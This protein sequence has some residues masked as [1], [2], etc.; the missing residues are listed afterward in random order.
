MNDADALSG[1]VRR[2]PLY[3]FYQKASYWGPVF[4]LYF[5]S[6]LTLP[7]VLLLEAVYYVAVVLLEVPTGQLADRIGGRRVLLAASLAQAGAC[8][9]FIASGSFAVLA[10]GQVL[11]ALGMSLG[12]GS[13]TAY[14]FALLQAARRE[15]E[16]GDREAVAARSILYSQALS[17]LVGGA[18]AVVDLRA[19]YALTLGS[20]LL[21]AWIAFRFVHV[22]L[23]DADRPE[24]TA[25]QL[26]SCLRDATHP[27]LAWL[28]AFY[29]Y[30]T[31]VNHVPHEFYQPYVGRLVETASFDVAPSAVTGLHTAA[32]MV[33]AGFAAAYSIKLRNRIG[34]TNTLLLAGGLQT[35]I[36]GAMAATLSPIVAALV[37]LRSCPRGLMQ[38]PMNAEIVPLV[39]RNRRATY[40]S[41]QSLFGRL[42]FGGVLVTLS[43][44]FDGNEIAAPIGVCA[45]GAAVGLAALVVAL[46]LARVRE[47]A[48]SDA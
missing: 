48:R 26:R 37:L 27:R 44:T 6:L 46:P 4:F 43:A 10:A 21:A 29:V 5:N 13:D 14:H 12:S 39:G 18:V 30:M 20:S 28:F 24:Q 35:L 17:A 47:R 36:I 3:L 42:A 40:L 16:Y 33:L 23:E 2:Y 9:A 7:D 34:T 1:S 31:V 19:A 11:L 45:I 41:L 15:D 25:A 32:T 38:A 22:D 8:A